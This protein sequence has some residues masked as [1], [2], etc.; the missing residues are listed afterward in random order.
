MECSLE[1]TAV[2]NWK[3]ILPHRTDVL[4][5]NI[6]EF[7][8]FIVYQERKNGLIQFQ[9]KSNK[10]NSSYYVDFGEPTYLAYISTNVDYNSS[11]L[12]YGFTSL[13]TPNSQS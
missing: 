10:N 12:R 5:E 1:K 2:E 7:K 6:E 3:E 11:T 8:D 13:V 9:V 4:L